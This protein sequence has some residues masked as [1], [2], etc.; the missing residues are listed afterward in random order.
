[1]EFLTIYSRKHFKHVNL[2]LLLVFI[3]CI[4][5]VGFV[6]QIYISKWYLLF[7]TVPLP[8]N[9]IDNKEESDFVFVAFA[10]VFSGIVR[11]GQKLYVLG[12]KHDP[13][14]V[15]KKVRVYIWE[16]DNS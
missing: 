12:P 15:L 7:F 2:Y 3:I 10:R 14:Q 11:K 9:D 13:S 16:K 6:K 5:L 1:M 4:L 8:E